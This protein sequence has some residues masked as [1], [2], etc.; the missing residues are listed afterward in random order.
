MP[1]LVRQGGSRLRPRE[2]QAQDDPIA[3]MVVLASSSIAE[4]RPLDVQAK[5]STVLEE[6]VKS[7]SAHSTVM[8]PWL[9]PFPADRPHPVVS[10][11]QGASPTSRRRQS[12]GTLSF[13]CFVMR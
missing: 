2:P 1:Q 7:I 13:L 9:L 8:A 6:M 11:Y 10:R 12:G 5:I 4:V 3:N